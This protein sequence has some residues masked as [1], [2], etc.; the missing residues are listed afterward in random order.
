MA[1]ENKKNLKEKL[2]VNEK[3]LGEKKVE[4]SENKIEDKKSEIKESVTSKIK[5]EL[6]KATSGKQDK[7]TVRTDEREY[8][9]PIA[10]KVRKVQK[11]RKAQIA[12]KIVKRFLARHMKVYDRDLNKIKIDRY[13]NDFIWSRG[14]KNPPSKVKVK[15]FKEN[16]VVRVELANISSHLSFKRNKLENRTLKASESGKKKVKNSEIQRPNEKTDE[17]VKEVKEKKAAV[18]DSGNKMERTAAKTMKH[19]TKDNNKQPKHQ[20]RKALAK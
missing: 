11:Y 15:V 10:V 4:T 20:Q 2:S 6:D 5:E 16:G 17:Q 7:K 3:S 19:T 9:I 14:I 18:I 12:I 1:E 13:L 8:V